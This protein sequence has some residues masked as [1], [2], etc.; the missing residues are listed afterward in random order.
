MALK[1]GCVSV[2]LAIVLSG[3]AINQ[4]NIGKVSGTAGGVLVGAGTGAII[5]KQV[6]GNSGA[7][8]GAGIGAIA[9][10][11]A[12]FFIGDYIDK[13]RAEQRKI[14][15]AKNVKI[16]FENIKKDGTSQK[17]DKVIIKDNNQFKSASSTLNP[18]AKDYYTQIAK[19]Y[20]AKNKKILIVGHTDDT[21]N[22][23]FNQKLS[24]KRARAVGKV[25]AQNGVSTKNIYYQG[26]GSTQPKA[27]NNTKK[28]R[29][30]NRR[31]EI[32]ELDNEADVAL[33]TSQN[34]TN[35]KFLTKTKKE[36]MQKT[37]QKSLK[38]TLAQ[39][40]KKDSKLPIT[41]GMDFGGIKSKNTLLALTDEFGKIQKNSFFSLATKA[42][43]DNN[44]MLNCLNTRYIDDTP[45]KSLAN[46]KELPKTSKFRKGLNASSWSANAGNHLI[47][48]APIAVLADNEVAKN[49]KVYLYKDYVV[50]SKAKANQAISTKTNTYN[51]SNGLLYRVYA[52]S[53]NASF[54]CMDIVFDNK[55]ASQAKGYM[56]YSANGDILEKEFELKPIKK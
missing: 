55:N 56:Y 17:N 11:I 31:V 3:C 19:T 27:D 34:I 43:A 40:S 23:A 33:Y 13:R 35:T 25:F 26:A 4:Q 22:S 50:G 18:N 1:K 36:V 14:S 8:V 46:D 42:Y 29:A 37:S 52:D 32:I 12:G 47:G 2:A 9:G 20:Q 48:I 38:E 54:E 10:G 51:G 39:T 15:E 28:G 7:L 5:G 44:I 30:E 16:E 41:Q 49:P 24:E 45:T 21:G 53:K 6:S